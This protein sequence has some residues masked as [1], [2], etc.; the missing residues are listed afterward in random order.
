MVDGRWEPGIFAAYPGYLR[1]RRVFSR[2]CRVFSA[3]SR[4][5][6]THVW[7]WPDTTDSELLTIYRCGCTCSC[8]PLVIRAISTFRLMVNAKSGMAEVR[9]GGVGRKFQERAT[10]SSK[11]VMGVDLS[12]RGGGT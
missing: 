6:K 7:Q 9:S 11:A 5:F 8:I 2:I 4:V 3:Y 12:F 1:I 10:Y